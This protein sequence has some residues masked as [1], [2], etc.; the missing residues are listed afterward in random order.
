VQVAELGEQ[1]FEL[2]ASMTGGERLEPAQ[3]LCELPLGADLA[4][5]AGLVPG[6]RDVHEPLE[7][8]AL[9]GGRRPPG[10]L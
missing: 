8:V 2:D 6:N 1:R 5:A 7:E 4:S 3:S 10:V 9:L